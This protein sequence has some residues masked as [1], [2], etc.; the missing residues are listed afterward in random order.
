MDKDVIDTRFQTDSATVI[1][2]L[3]SLL[4]ILGKDALLENADNDEDASKNKV[5]FHY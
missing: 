3:N 2:K 1:V 4:V 5:F